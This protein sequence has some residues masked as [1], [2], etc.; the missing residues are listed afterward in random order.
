MSTILIIDDD[1]A[2]REVVRLSLE[3]VGYS[4]LEA[5]NGKEGVE[6]AGRSLP[7][8]ILCDV[9]MEHMN[10]YDT[11]SAL[12][13][14]TVTTSIP[15]ILMTGQAD[16]EGMRQGMELGADDYLP[17]PFKLDQLIG[18]VEARLR[19]QQTLKD[20]AAKQLSELR[21]NISLSLPHELLTPLNG[22]FGFADILATDARTLQ[23][24]EVE[25]M[26]TA[27][28]ESAERL[29]RLIQSFLL[30][31][32]LQ[33]HGDDP[34]PLISETG[35]EKLRRAVEEISR[36]RAATAGRKADLQLSVMEAEATVR[37][38]HWTKM[39]EE[40]V[41]NA[42]KFSEPQTPVY[43]S[44]ESDGAWAILRVG[45]RGR[46]MR[47]EHLAEIGAYMQFERRFY[48]QQ[49]SGLGL[50]ITK[51]LAE[52]YGGRLRVTSEVGQGTEA[53][54]TLPLAE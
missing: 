31:A 40:L 29:H 52:M 5:A 19:K 25:S 42:F 23:P 37:A 20:Q 49:G 14:N 51:R 33:L 12:R 2:L 6:R 45:D 24:D 34:S 48:E 47:P 17:K 39:V 11:L 41:D 7:D 46:G 18:A 30:L 28:R 9:R 1:E 21:A 53:E 4:V 10:G 54:L 36:T 16:A 15:V 27:I 43:V 32:Q 3:N 35:R 8:L 44:L 22:I 13:Q 38:D 26:A 50:A